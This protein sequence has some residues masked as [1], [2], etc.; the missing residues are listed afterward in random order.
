MRWLCPTKVTFRYFSCLRKVILYDFANP[1]RWLRQFWLDLSWNWAGP[2]KSSSGVTKSRKMTCQGFADSGLQQ[3]GIG[4]APVSYLPAS[5]NHGRWLTGA[6]RI[7]ACDKPES[8]RA[9]EVIF[10]DLVMTE[11]HLAKSEKRIW[12]T[13]NSAERT[14]PEIA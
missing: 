9:W 2:G 14:Y 6:W 5:P 12:W 1:I 4:H 13:F 11:S 10:R 3:A 7:L 8:A